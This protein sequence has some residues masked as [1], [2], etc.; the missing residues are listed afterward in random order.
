MIWINKTNDE[1]NFWNCA[2]AVD[3]IVRE[4][5]TNSNRKF[6]STSKMEN[7]GQRKNGWNNINMVMCTHTENEQRGKKYAN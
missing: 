2:Y 4:Y 1:Q 6:Y 7:V 5:F 3:A